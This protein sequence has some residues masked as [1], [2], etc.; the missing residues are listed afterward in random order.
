MQKDFQILDSEYDNNSLR[1]HAHASCKLQAYILHISS[2]KFRYATDHQAVSRTSWK[3]WFKLNNVL[4]GKE[5]KGIQYSLFLYQTSSVFCLTTPSTETWSSISKYGANI[6][7]ET[8]LKSSKVR[9]LKR[10]DNRAQNKSM[11]KLLASDFFQPKKRC[12]Q[13]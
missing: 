12:V 6:C 3:L 9:E 1:F 11:V 5:R 4:E 10:A 7:K 8:I 2:A 13:W